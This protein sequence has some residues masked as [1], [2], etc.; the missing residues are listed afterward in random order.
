MKTIIFLSAL[1]TASVVSATSVSAG[2]TI[3]FGL[4]VPLSG[5]GAPF[6]KASLYMCQQ[7]AAEIKNAGGIK[8]KGKA[9]NVECIAYDNKY[10]AAEGAKVA[11]TLVNRDGVKYMCA[12]GSAPIA[13][14]Q[15]LTER[16]EVLLFSQ[17]WAKGSKGPKYPLTF[18]DIVTPFEVGPAMIKFITSTYPAAKTVAMLNVSDSTGRE[19]EQA[20]RP[21]WEK[22]GLRVVTSDFYERG[23]TE[24][25]PI[26]QRLAS[27]KPDVVELGSALPPDAGQI[28][29]ELSVL[30]WK[31]VKVATASTAAEGL[32]ATGGPAAEGV[33]MG[34]ALTFDGPNATPLQRRLNAGQVPVSG[35]SLG[36]ASIPC[37]DAVHMLK[38]GAEYA[39]SLEPTAIA[40]VMPKVKFNSFFGDDIG[41]GGKDIYGSNVQPMLPVY[42]TQ[43]VNAKVVE[44]AKVLPR[45]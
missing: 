39:Q 1:A 33:Y 24:F 23:T 25:Q 20:L 32:I 9:Y 34:A 5:A 27:L 22:A 40:A 13:A 14:A 16:Q 6:G 2:E 15:S 8:V 10:T 36:L 7:A 41:F 21:M 45:P 26:A 44:R 31:G 42:I 3:K 38:A 4:S 35:E 11:Q 43:I 18:S 28:F 30:G 12:V 29:K 37:Y 19:S 17:G